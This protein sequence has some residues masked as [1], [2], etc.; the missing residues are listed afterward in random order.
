[1]ERYTLIAQVS[2]VSLNTITVYNNV[3]RCVESIQNVSA[4][5]L[6]GIMLA[7]IEGYNITEV[8]F[9]GTECFAKGIGNKLNNVTNYNKLKIKYVM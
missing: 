5:E 4:S 8:I 1:M 6:H 2:P 7:T 9:Q 3:D